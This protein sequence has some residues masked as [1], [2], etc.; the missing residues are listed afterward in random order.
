MSTP[1]ATRVRRHGDDAIATPANLVT[2]ARLIL[3]VPTLLLIIDQGSSWLT[4]SLWFVLTTTDGLDGW[5]ARRDGTTR[6]GAFLDPLADKFLVL[7]G[8]FALG[9][10]GDFSWAAVLIVTV[11][12]VGVSM[13][14]SYAARRGISLPARK[15]GKWKA[16]FQ[17]L[18]VGV[19]LLPPTYEWA[20]FHDILLWFAV[21]LSVVS[22]LD[23]VISGQRQARS[24]QEGC[25]GCGVT[26]S[27]SAPSS[28]SARSS[29]PTARGSA[30]SSPPPAST[31]ASTARSATTSI[32]WCSACGSCSTGPTRS[33]V[34]GGL[35]PTPDDVTR[36]AIA[37]VM[38]VELERREELIEHI[39]A[40]F[41]GR[42]RPFPENNLRQADVPGRRRRHPESARHRARAAVRGRTAR[43]CTRCPACP[44]R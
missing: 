1:P 34:C 24:S 19:V 7:G 27:P 3:A 33:I 20:T 12:E 9:I 32:A 23:I 22:G 21:A 26:C 30:S 14:R 43:S 17:F 6:S 8:F 31:R 39:R 11:R 40:I 42:G 25:F 44:T 36:E 2:I 15:L 35:G 5:L 41:G 18:A 10:N 4:V 37:E 13:Y 29:T 38:G 16:F 28:C